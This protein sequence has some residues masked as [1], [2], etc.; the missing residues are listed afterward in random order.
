MLHFRSKPL[1]EAAEKF[2]T[3]MATSGRSPNTV[4]LYR[5]TL[6]HFHRFLAQ[7]RITV[8]EFSALMLKEY[9][10]DLTRHGLKLITRKANIGH[11]HIYLRWLEASARI[12]P[13]LSQRLFP[14]YRG[15][16]VKGQQAELPEL[17]I[18]FL[19]VMAATSKKNTVNGYQTALRG[20]YRLH[21]MKAEAK[22][23]RID[24]ADI[25]TY[26]IH[27][28]D[29]EMGPNER[30]ARLLQIRKYLDWLYDHRKLKVHPDILIKS[31]DFPKRIKHLPRPFPVNVDIELQKRLDENG[32][33]D[34]LGVLLM[35]RTGLRVGELCN[36]TLDCITTD[37]N[38]NWFLKVPLGKLN[39][40][41]V[42]PLDP[43][44]VEVVQ[45][46]QKFHPS[47]SAPE[48]GR[49]FLISNPSGRRRSRAH[50]A[51]VLEEATKDLAIPGK[52]TLHRLRH[53]FA[54][55]LLSAG[56][57]I[58]TLKQLLGHNDIRMTLN[59]AAVT[60]E[61]VRTEFLEALAKNQSRYETAA[62]PLKL[63]DQ[64][65]GMNRAIYDAQKYAKK[66][67]RDRADIDPD[68]IRRL[69]G[70]LMAIR[71][72]LSDLLM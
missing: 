14:N 43:K 5:A 62:Y 50:F 63:P 57:P 51:I 68:K 70:R 39:S 38:D 36:L 69:L 10:E 65:E 9:D 47:E 2:L 54:T 32:G 1:P 56:L 8:S 24:R 13:G 41:R 52:V 27:L 42:I 66:I 17:A 53:T 44:T 45:R 48:V 60:L 12:E 46:I 49:R 19:E 28:K 72:E 25:E 23:Y 3:E 35:R 4:S 59:Y 16:V 33:I 67:A 64:R 26:M 34:F 31:A 29:K 6:H 22:P 61:T 21:Q 15:D 55:T 71:Q 18:R 40:E 58:T 30:G 37:M 11:I 7:Q 20:F